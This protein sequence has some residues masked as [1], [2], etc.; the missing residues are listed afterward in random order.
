MLSSVC[1]LAGSTDAGPSP[2]LSWAELACRDGTSYPTKWRATRAA[3]L[4]SAF[5]SV[6]LACGNQPLKVLS[7]YR[8]AAWNAKVGGAVAS[9]HIHGRALDLH[10]PAGMSLRAFARLVRASSLAAGIHGIG[11]Y[12]TFVHIDVRPTDGLV[13]WMGARSQA[14]AL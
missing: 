2:H 11:Y 5:E 4:A 3:A 14:E 8:T 7:G 13:L 12:S 6:R 10:P 1:C 9:Q